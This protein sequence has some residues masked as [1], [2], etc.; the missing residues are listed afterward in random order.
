MFLCVSDN[1][2]SSS[3]SNEGFGISGAPVPKPDEDK[4]TEAVEQFCLSCVWQQWS[5]RGKSPDIMWSLD[6]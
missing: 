3:L 6:K 2:I 4:R 5:K 1:R